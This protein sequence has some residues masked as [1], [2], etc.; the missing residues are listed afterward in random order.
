MDVSNFAVVGGMARRVYR[1]HCGPMRWA[2][3]RDDLGRE[4]VGL[5]SEIERAGPRTGRNVLGGLGP[6]AMTGNAW[7][8]PRTW[9]ARTRRDAWF[10]DQAT[11]LPPFL[12]PPTV[13]D[14]T[15]FEQHV[16]TAR[17]RRGLGM[18]PDW[19][20]LPVF[21]FSNPASRS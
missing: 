20:E 7:R 3:F 19:Y 11:A 14:F 5:V 12:R 21:Y 1:L 6:R 15:A 4:R 8:H 17:E 13:R 18:D 2:S 16:K 9:P 10:L